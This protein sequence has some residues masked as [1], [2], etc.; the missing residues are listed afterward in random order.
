MHLSNVKTR[1]RLVPGLVSITFRALGPEAIVEL[2]QR[3]GLRAIEWGA[4]VHVPPTDVGRARA[5]G[6]RTRE[7]GLEVSSYGSY[8]KAGRDPHSFAAILPS[9][10]A[11]GAPRI[12]VW[13]VEFHGGTL[14]SNAASTAELLRAVEGLETYWQ[15]RVGATPEAVLADIQ[16]LAPSLCHAH[17]FQWD[18]C[19]ARYPLSDGATCWPR[20]LAALAQLD[21]PIHVQLEY[22][23]D[24]RPDQLVEDAATLMGWIAK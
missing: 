17:V 19:A 7:A 5:V 9:A 21:R 13:A 23:K 12:R 3:A 10:V 4:D 2:V 22:V 16:A 8:Y 1:P 14:T 15:P 20:Y 24:D 18:A 6:I 11:L